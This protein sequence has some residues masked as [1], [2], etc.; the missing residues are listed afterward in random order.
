MVKRADVRDC[1]LG[2]VVSDL[3]LFARR[4]C[5]EERMRS[6][7]EPLSRAGLVILNGDTF[8]FRWSEHGNFDD[9]RAAAIQWLR[10]LVSKFSNCEVHYILGNH[11]CL[12]SFTSDLESLSKSSSAFHWHRRWLRIGSSLFLHGDCVHRMMDGN[13][14]ELYRETWVNDSPRGHGAAV[15]YR[16]IDI[17]GITRFGQA[18]HFPAQRALRRLAHYLEDVQPRWTDTFSDCY[19]GHTHRPFSNRLFRGVRFHNTGS[20]IRGMPFNPICFPLNADWRR[21]VVTA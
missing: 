2:V 5:A 10:S 1:Q 4:S 7:Q 14:L 12:E 20:A 17:L 19:F 11:D 8:D 9:S 13:G 6:L 21:M 16:F 15:A 3:H 18:W